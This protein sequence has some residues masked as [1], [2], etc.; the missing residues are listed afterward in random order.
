MKHKEAFQSNK[1]SSEYLNEGLS[2]LFI[3]EIKAVDVG[4][5]SAQ[6]DVAIA[7]VGV[8]VHFMLL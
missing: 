3:R 1:Q 4:K 8:P 5:N 7:M 6:C 2:L